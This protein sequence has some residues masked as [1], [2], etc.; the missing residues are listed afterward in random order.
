MP[1]SLCLAL[2]GRRSWGGSPASLHWLVHAGD[3]LDS[4]RPVARLA[5]AID[6]RA[7]DGVHGTL[8]TLLVDDGARVAAGNPLLTYLPDNHG[9]RHADPGP[10]LAEEA[11]PFARSSGPSQIIDA[12]VTDM[13]RVRSI[14]AVG[15]I[16]LVGLATTVATT[17]V[18]FLFG[19]LTP[20]LV[21]A[22]ALSVA[23]VSLLYGERQLH[24]DD[25]YPG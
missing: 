11:P 14:A 1:R 23:A 10:E 17:L 12:E 9:E 4:G 24:G 3:R 20:L 22:L 7:P 25:G 15:L 21:G 16:S 5:G 8:R 19:G 18:Y 2:P 6:V 13:K